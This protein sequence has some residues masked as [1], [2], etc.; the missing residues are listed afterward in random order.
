MWRG[1]A[2]VRR[3]PSS[4]TPRLGRR[5][6]PRLC[7]G[8][9]R[10]CAG[11]ARGRPPALRLPRPVAAGSWSGTSSPDCPWETAWRQPRMSVAITGRP[12]GR[13][14]HGRSGEALTVRRQHEEVEGRVDALHVVPVAGEDDVPTAP[15]GGESPRV[16]WHRP[17]RDPILRRR[18]TTTS[19]CVSRRRSAAAKSSRKPFC[20]TRRATIPTTTASLVDAEIGPG[21][22]WRLA[23]SAPG[24]K[25]CSST[26]FPSSTSL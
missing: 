14:F 12:H 13:R 8:P 19:G 24:R 10:P 17:C 20:Q 21:P 11:G 23:P 5:T 16:R 15:G 6:R 26:P 4:W 7:A 9:R 3:R 2:P 22:T 25:R 18:R 1:R